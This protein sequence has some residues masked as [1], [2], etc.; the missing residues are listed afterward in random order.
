VQPNQAEAAEGAR[1]VKRRPVGA[2]IERR[3]RDARAPGSANRITA[4]Q[5][6]E[7][8]RNYLK[9]RDEDIKLHP[10]A[11]G[12]PHWDLW[13]MDREWEN[14]LFAVI[15]F[16]PPPRGIEF[17]CGTGGSS[18]VRAFCEHDAPD[19]PAGLFDQMRGRFRVPRGRLRVNRGAAERWLGREW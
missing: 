13:M 4:R 16:W 7:W 6:R 14:A 12:W 19:D 18:P 10:E 17:F 9:S 3:L 5:L 1:V 8:T 15:S 2:E 11:A